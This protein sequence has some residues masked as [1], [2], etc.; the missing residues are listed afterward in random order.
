[1]LRRYSSF[2]LSDIAK[3]EKTLSAIV[4]CSKR[5]SH[6]FS[7]YNDLNFIVYNTNS[8]EED[9]NENVLIFRAL[10]PSPDWFI[11]HMKA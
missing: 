2:S 7:I 5:L 8:I 9:S 11:Y 10:M 4:E 1:M 3:N 6:E